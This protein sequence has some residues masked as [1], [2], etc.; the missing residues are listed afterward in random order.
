MKRHGG[1]VIKEPAGFALVGS[2]PP[3]R[4]SAVDNHFR[5]ILGKKAL[6]DRKVTQVVITA[7][8]REDVDVTALPEFSDNITPE[9]AASSRN[10]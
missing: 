1:I 2:D 9:E 4:S 5:L 10:K 3:Y 8:W 7:S 6:Y